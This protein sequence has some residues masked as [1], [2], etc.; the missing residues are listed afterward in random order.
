MVKHSSNGRALMQA[1]SPDV[2][3][4]TRC[5]V[6][7]RRLAD[8]NAPV[9]SRC[10]DGVEFHFHKFLTCHVA[11][12]YNTHHGQRSSLVPRSAWWFI[13]TLSAIDLNDKSQRIARIRV[14]CRYLAI[15]VANRSSRKM[16]DQWKIPR[17]KKA[18]RFAFRYI[19][20]RFDLQFDSREFNS[21]SVRFVLA[22]SL[23]KLLRP[24][25]AP[26]QFVI[27]LRQR[28]VRCIYQNEI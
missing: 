4:T 20:S 7:V 19:S 15:R 11:L 5:A 12:K 28:P 8:A 6:S 27:V 3:E 25:Y 9:A 24:P 1:V 2:W 18:R 23:S 10:W 13:A 22:L 17:Q 16:N 14:I 26:S 21:R